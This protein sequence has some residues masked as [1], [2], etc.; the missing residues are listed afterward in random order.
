MDPIL[1]EGVYVG[2]G[3]KILGHITIGEWSVIGAN[4]VVTSDVPPFSI[5]VGNN[6]IL[7]KK[8]T[9]I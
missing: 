7:E 4:A 3:A 5:A 1:K 9:E 6:R 2:P 8:T